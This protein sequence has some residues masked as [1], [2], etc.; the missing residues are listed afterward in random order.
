MKTQLRHLIK[1]ATFLP[2]F[3]INVIT[4]VNPESRQTE[5]QKKLRLFK[6]NALKNIDIKTTT[7]HLTKH[8]V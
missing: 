8:G 7:L 2:T 4:P 3:L 5:I 6:K 1:L